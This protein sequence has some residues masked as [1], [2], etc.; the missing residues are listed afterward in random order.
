M[1]RVRLTDVQTC[2]TEFLDGTSVPLEALQQLVPPFEV[3][4]QAHLAASRLDGTPRGPPVGARC[5]RT[6]R[7]QHRK[8]DGSSCSRSSRPMPSRWGTGACAVWARAQPI[9]GS[10]SSCLSCLQPSAA[11][12]MPRLAP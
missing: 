4:F 7:S 3:A 12:A 1:A 6:L 5:T 11:S 10:M 2:S 8:I 9:S